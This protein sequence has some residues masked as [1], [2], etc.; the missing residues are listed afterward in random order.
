MRIAAILKGLEQACCLVVYLGV[1]IE[2]R[3]RPEPCQHPVA[4]AKEDS[5]VNVQFER[6]FD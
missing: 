5:E 3:R 1:A 2:E 6:I 4:A